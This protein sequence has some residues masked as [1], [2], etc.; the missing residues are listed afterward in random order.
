MLGLLALPARGQQPASTD[1]TAQINGYERAAHSSLVGVPTDWSTSHLV[2]STPEP[3]SDA[4]DKVQQDPRYWLQQIRRAQLQ[5]DDSIAEASEARGITD[6]KSN[7]KKK[8]K[9]KKGVIGTDWSASLGTGG[10]AGADVFPA[11]FTFGTVAATCVTSTTLPPTGDFVVF[12]TSLPGSGT[13][14]SVIAFANLYSSCAGTVPSTYWA[15]NTGGTATTSVALSKDGSQV[16]FMQAVGTTANLVLLKWLP[17]VR[18]VPAQLTTGSG[19]ITTTNPTFTA[20]DVGAAITGT[21]IPATTTISAVTNST[22]A[23]ISHNATATSTTNVTITVTETATSPKS[24]VVAAN[25]AYRTCVAPCMTSFAFTGT[26]PLTDTNSSPFADLPD[27]TIYVGG[28][29]GFLHKYTGVFLGTPAEVTSGFPAQAAI[30]PLSSPVLDFAAGKVF[31]TAAYD[32]TSNGGRL[33]A[34]DATLG[35]TVAS[36][37]LGP[38]TAA[39]ANCAGTTAGGV[40]QTLDG[41]ILDGAAG[42]NGTVYVVI[43]NDGSAANSGAGSSAV[44]QFAAGFAAGTCGSEITLGVGSTTGVP[45]YSGT[46]DNIYFISSDPSPTGNLYVCGNAGGSATLYRVPIASNVMSTASNV[47]TALSTAN[48]TCSPVTEFLNGA[49]DRA[50]LSVQTFANTAANIGCPTGGAAGGC[51]MS[52]NITSG[53][54]PTTTSAKANA[55]GGTSGIV[56]DNASATVGASQVYFS[57][58]GTGSSAIQASQ[59]GLN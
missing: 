2:F 50:F 43:G 14:A 27:D 47:A 19:T 3:G 18:T 6:G 58:L 4:E 30:E 37:Q 26:A 8:K 34:I 23:T 40:A 35:T 53:T 33:H 38:T 12:N 42:T 22:T 45:V 5:A 46:F 56:I 36:K 29:N 20:V 54:T 17:A 11:K 9:L 7:K 13:Q 1:L 28:D 52:F 10:K 32:G 25:A 49:T 41:P 48:T 44:Y 21:G 57:T 39:G 24:P 59:S 16:A 51:V 55:P 31:V 15:Y